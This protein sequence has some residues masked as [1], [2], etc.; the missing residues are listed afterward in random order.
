MFIRLLA[1]FTV[2]PFIELVLLIQRIHLIGTG[3]TGG[4]VRGQGVGG[5][6]GAGDPEDVG[7][8]LS[9][10]THWPEPADQGKRENATAV[11]LQGRVRNRRALRPIEQWLRPG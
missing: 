1:L 8:G 6:E 3:P 2:I 7:L 9:G 11:R 4:V 5:R 10:R